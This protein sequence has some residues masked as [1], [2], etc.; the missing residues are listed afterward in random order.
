M[1]R[2]Y[3]AAGNQRHSRRPARKGGRRNQTDSRNPVL[4]RVAQ[5]SKSALCWH[6][7]WAPWQWS[8]GGLC[9]VVWR[10]R[11]TRCTS[12]LGYSPLPPGSPDPSA[13]PRA[14]LCTPIASWPSR[15]LREGFASDAQTHVRTRRV[16][17]PSRRGTWSLTGPLLVCGERVGET[18]GLIWCVL[19]SFS[20]G[21]RVGLLAAWR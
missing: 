9:A 12:S 6:A 16:R 4:V 15:S 3:T 10:V 11:G 7:C 5:R 19:P 21:S 17:G 18:P 1:R 14:A 8:R 20:R 13:L 2:P